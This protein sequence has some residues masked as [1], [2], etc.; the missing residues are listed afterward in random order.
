MVSYILRELKE[1]LST[2]FSPDAKKMKL[3]DEKRSSATVALLQCLAIPV[4]VM[5][6]F[7]WLITLH[8]PLREEKGVSAFSFVK[9]RRLYSETESDIYLRA[10]SGWNTT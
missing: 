3:N 8:L 1:A 9:R 7:L 4:V 6:G 10:K 5:W 2:P